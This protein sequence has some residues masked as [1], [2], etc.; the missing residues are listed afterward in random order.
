MKKFIFGVFL[1][2]SLTFFVS[3]AISQPFDDI[4]GPPSK[5]Q[6]EKLRKR[7]ETLKMW[8]LTKTLDLNEES[9][10]RLFPLINKYD[11]KRF[12][13][14]QKMRKDMRKLR[15]TVDTLSESELSIIIERL[16]GNHRRL[17]EISHEEI[18]KLS[19]MLTTREMAKFIIFKHDFN[20]EMKKIITK[21]RGKTHEEIKR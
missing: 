5:E 3:E 4:K 15:K 7:V 12:A 1:T 10:S 20:R 18:Q 16:K 9:A 21:V 8:R 6:R 19:D 2:V 14:M 11:K 17:Q 13:V